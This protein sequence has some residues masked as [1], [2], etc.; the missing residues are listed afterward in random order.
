MIGLNENRRRFLGFSIFCML[1]WPV[2]P[3]VLVNVWFY[4]I[5]FIAPIEIGYMVYKVYY[6]LKEMYA[7]DRILPW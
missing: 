7:R 6:S 3:T 4:F 2:I 1:L 5:F